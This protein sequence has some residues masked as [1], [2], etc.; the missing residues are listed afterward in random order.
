MTSEIIKKQEGKYWALDA[1]DLLERFKEYAKTHYSDVY[2]DFSV[3]SNGIMLAEFMTI[4]GDVNN[5]RIDH[6]YDEQFL[7]TATE[8][9]TLFKK[10]NSEGYK[11]PGKAPASGYCNFYMTVDA[12][13]SGSTF[14]PDLNY[15]L[16]LKRGSRA[17]KKGTPYELIE[18]LKFSDVDYKNKTQV[19]VK[20][21]NSTGVVTQYALKK[22]G[23]VV[24]GLTKTHS[25]V[26][27]AYEEYRTITLPDMDVSQI[28]DVT[29][30]EGNTWYEVDYLA[31]DTVFVGESNTASDKSLVPSVLLARPA[32]Y[33]F[34]VRR[35]PSSKKWELQFGAGSAND[36]DTDIIP[37][38][39]DLA[40]P[41]WGKT[42]FTDP[43]IDPQNFLK[44][45]TFGMAPTNTTLTIKY[46]TGGGI[47]TNAA[48]GEI[49]TM[50][51]TKYEELVS[52]LSSAKLAEVIS[53]ISVANDEPISGGSDGLSIEQ[54]KLMIKAFKAS[55]MRCVTL[56]DYMYK[57]YSMPSEYGSVFRAYAKRNPLN[58]N[59]VQLYVLAKDQYGHLQNA[60]ST[61]KTNLQTF[62]KNT[63]Q[64]SVDIMDCY[65]VNLA[66]Y[67]TIV[68]DK[69]RNEHEVLTECIQKL[70]NH[71]N[72][73]NWQ[74]G[75][76]IVLSQISDLLD[77]VNSVYSVAS[78]QVTNRCGYYGNRLYGNKLFGV[79]ENTKN[80]I[81]YCPQNTIFEVKFNT[82]DILSRVL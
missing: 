63:T 27:G 10:A 17:Y 24:A 53:S 38:V 56:T 49:N 37:N 76:P 47:T 12:T 61:L 45:K 79:E 75:Q 60:T 82:Q 18:D 8:P 11:I 59:A 40:L 21:R 29:D 41:L 64:D 50:G 9:K 5:A 19:V 52:G 1:N 51:E 74:I 23:K 44:T 68:T 16:T 48:V 13:I 36:A 43:H 70:R 30:S 2:K 25:A 69:T 81:I 15:A 4:V 39:G 31:Q 32:P 66:I 14:M 62:F 28:V 57:A 65:I 58:K 22:R 34:V 20:T 71:F 67:F 55:Q 73:D 72:V 3:A 6:N 42:N 46:R 80:G 78:I 35:N 33:R 77:D 54:L 26:I 7:D